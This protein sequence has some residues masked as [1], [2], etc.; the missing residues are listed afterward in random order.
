MYVVRIWVAQPVVVELSTKFVDQCKGF[1]DN[2]NSR[3][4]LSVYPSLVGSTSSCVVGGYNADNGGV[5]NMIGD[6]SPLC[7]DFAHKILG[8]IE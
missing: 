5:E 3:W 1:V 7:L 2:F 6:V 8:I 4:S